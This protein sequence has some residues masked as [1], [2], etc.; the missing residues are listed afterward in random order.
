MKTRVRHLHARFRNIAT[1]AD[2]LDV[3]DRLC[4]AGHLMIGD[5]DAITY[6]L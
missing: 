4:K 2:V 5:K 6:H 1:E 3:A